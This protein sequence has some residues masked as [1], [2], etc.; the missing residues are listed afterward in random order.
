MKQE[1]YT[2]EERIEIRKQR[3][4]AMRLAKEAASKRGYTIDPRIAV[5]RATGKEE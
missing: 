4:I 5:A 2:E 1:Y 3:K